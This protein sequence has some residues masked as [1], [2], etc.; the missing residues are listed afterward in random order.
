MINGEG[1]FSGV[2]S[3]QPFGNMENVACFVGETYYSLG[4]KDPAVLIVQEIT[5]PDVCEVLRNGGILK[6]G[7]D[8]AR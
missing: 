6:D 7:A 5:G 1:F 3:Y 4:E 8:T 2:F